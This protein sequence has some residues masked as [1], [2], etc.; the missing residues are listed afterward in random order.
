MNT[1]IGAMDKIDRV[2][3]HWRDERT[4]LVAQGGGLL[5]QF[6]F[7]VRG[8]LVEISPDRILFNTGTEILFYGSELKRGDNGPCLLLEMCGHS[9][10]VEPVAARAP[11][12]TRQTI[13]RG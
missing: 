6:G 11:Q 5:G 13:R 9:I 4:P 10:A 3:R 1:Y 2:L 12:V 7:I 8:H